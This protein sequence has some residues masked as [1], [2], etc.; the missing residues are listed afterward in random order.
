MTLYSINEE[1]G[2]PL[3]YQQCL[4]LTSVCKVQYRE[5]L[6]YDFLTEI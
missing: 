4:N 5:F 2:Y 6:S 3:A 1:E